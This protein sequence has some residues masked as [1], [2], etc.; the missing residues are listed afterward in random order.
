LNI[1]ANNVDM[2]FGNGL[3]A[4]ELKNDINLSSH[5][6]AAGVSDSVGASEED[7]AREIIVLREWLKR[8]PGKKITYFSSFA[9]VSSDSRYAKH[10]R[11]VEEIIKNSCDKYN[12]IRLPQVVGISSNMTLVSFL[13]RSIIKGHE[14]KIQLKARRRLIGVEDV[15]RLARQIA[16]SGPE[17]LVVNV[18]PPHSISA[19]EIL[20]KVEEI[21]SIDAKYSLVNGGDIQDAPLNDILTYLAASDPLLAEN[22]QN[23]VLLK[24]VPKIAKC[25]ET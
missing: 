22:Y 21:L 15:A 14:L 23:Q 10:K 13:V 12:I 24:Y 9:A 2:V 25:Y 4:S 7:Y 11:L 16:R 19:L 18:G 6:F 20:K 3:L 5:F 8:L 17:K 1:K